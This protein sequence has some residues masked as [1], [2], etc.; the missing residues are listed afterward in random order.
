MFIRRIKW[1][2]EKYWYGLFV[3]RSHIIKTKL[4]V[5]AWYP[6]AMRLLYGS[7]RLLEDFVEKSGTFE[8]Y[9]WEW[10]KGHRH[11]R[12]EIL[13]IYKWW[14]NYEERLKDLDVMLDSLYYETNPELQNAKLHYHTY[15]EDCLDKETKEMLIRLAQILDYLYE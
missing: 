10:E 8:V 14:K 6:T 13:T 4:P 3:N 12:K 7:M 9:D 11:A 15:L 1:W 2:L 5:D